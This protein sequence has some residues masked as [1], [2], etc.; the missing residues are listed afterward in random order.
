MIEKSNEPIK[1]TTETL[2]PQFGIVSDADRVTSA[3]EM[4]SYARKPFLKLEQL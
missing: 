4:S 3:L 2:S 1:K